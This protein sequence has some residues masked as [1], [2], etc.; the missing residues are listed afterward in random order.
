MREQTMIDHLGMIKEVLGDRPLMTCCAGTGPMDLSGRALNLERM[1]P[2]VDLL[3]LENVGLGLD[4]ALLA[5]ARG[6]GDAAAGP[7]PAAGQ[8]AG[9]GAAVHLRS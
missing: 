9:A 5:P 1:L 7:G 3:M 6:R 4:G 2:H 8:C